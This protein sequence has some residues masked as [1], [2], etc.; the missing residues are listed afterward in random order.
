[1]PG[2]INMSPYELAALTYIG[3]FVSFGDTEDL[4]IMSLVLG[5]FASA[6]YRRRCYC[7]P[8]WLRPTR[9]RLRRTAVSTRQL[10]AR[11]KAE[12]RVRRT[13]QRLQQQAEERQGQQRQYQQLEDLARQRREFIQ[14][15]LDER[16]EQEFQQRLAEV[17]LSL[18]TS[19]SP[20]PP[21]LRTRPIG[22]DSS[23]EEEPFNYSA[24]TVRLIKLHQR[25]RYIQKYGFDPL[26]D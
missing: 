1:M 18:S 12:D 20:S 4:A 24:E 13:R 3:L 22:A 25:I 16:E 10:Q 23:D 17:E 9:L 21:P 7:S 2:N 26:Q 11:R 15:W 5:F 14:Q 6:R 8:P 19:S